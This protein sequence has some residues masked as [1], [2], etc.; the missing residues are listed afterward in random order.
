MR[1]N[2]NLPKRT[3]QQ[4]KGGS[5]FPNQ[6]FDWRKECHQPNKDVYGGFFWSILHRLTSIG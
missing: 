5:P 3:S 6:N 4:E 2:K 1:E